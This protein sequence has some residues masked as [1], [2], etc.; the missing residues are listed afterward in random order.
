MRLIE[1]RL[2]AIQ[3][4]SW[5]RLSQIALC[6]VALAFVGIYLYLV[7][8][9]LFYAYSLEWFEGGMLRHVQRVLQGQALYVPPTVEFTSFVYPPLYVWLSAGLAQVMGL[10]YLPLRV[11]SFV[12]SIAGVGAIFQLVRA[13]TGRAFLG[14]IAAALYLAMF[15]ISNAWYDVGRVDSLLIAFLLWA[16]CILRQA[17]AQERGRGW[18]FFTAGL[19]FSLAYL[20]K[21]SA[22]GPALLMTAY[23]VFKYRW[24]AWPL[25]AALLIGAGGSTFILNASSNGWFIFYNFQVLGQH[26]WIRDLFINFWTKDLLGP[27]PI[28]IVLALVGGVI[29]ILGRR[30]I[31]FWLCAAASL[32]VMALL[33]RVHTGGGLNTLM[34]AYALFAVLFGVGLGMLFHGASALPAEWQFP[35]QI[36]LNLVALVQFACL[37]YTPGLHVP[38]ADAW[39]A[40]AQLVERI[41][42]APGEVFMPFHEQDVLLAGKSAWANLACMNEILRIDVPQNEML[43]ADFVATFK[44]HR[45]AMVIVDASYLFPGLTEYYQLVDEIHYAPESLPVGWFFETLQVYV[46]KT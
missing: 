7:S 5:A 6:A 12:A 39:Q 37:V 10:S 3:A 43:R 46:P 42:H 33:S 45:F 14:F 32:L 11:V 34:P 18:K 21:Q 22:I 15:R 31:L 38:D 26:P 19:L 35:V 28:A 25:A 36:C 41:R 40:N 13:E 29:R 16:L 20:T 24:H 2:G 9:R 23:A 30:D 4:K 44:A 1:Q 17:E 8:Q 27:L